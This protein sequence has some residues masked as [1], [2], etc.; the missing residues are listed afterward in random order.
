MQTAFHLA[1][2]VLFLG[3]A[4]AMILYEL[5]RL[6]TDPPFPKG[7]GL[8]SLYWMTYL[9]CIVLGVTFAFAAV[10]R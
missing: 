3:I 4:G 7:E 1:A 9:S 6:R 10:I 8:R 5:A 2:T